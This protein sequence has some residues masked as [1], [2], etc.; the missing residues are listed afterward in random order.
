MTVMEKLE[1]FNAA[2][3]WSWYEMSKQAGLSEATVYTWRRKGTSPSVAAL[4]KICDAYGITLYQFF[5]DVG[6]SGLSDVQ[7][8]VLTVWSALDEEERAELA[9]LAD[10]FIKR[11]RNKR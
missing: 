9:R 2:R 1:E 3:G 11:K 10:F 6:D 8:E 5:N 7:S 4:Q